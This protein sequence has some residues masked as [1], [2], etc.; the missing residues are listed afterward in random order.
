MSAPTV[1]RIAND[2]FLHV[3]ISVLT[4]LMEIFY[5]YIFLAG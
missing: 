1:H 4:L 3:A 2:C 5:Q